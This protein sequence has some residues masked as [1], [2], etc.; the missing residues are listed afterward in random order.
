MKGNYIGLTAIIDRVK[1]N[2]L[3]RGLDF[4]IAVRYAIDCI[5]LIGS[6]EILTE[7]PYRIGIRDYR[8]ILPNNI[9]VLHQARR[10]FLDDT[11]KE[12]Y[13]PMREATDTFHNVYNVSNLATKFSSNG[14]IPENAYSINEYYIHTGFEEGVVDIMYSGIAVDTYGYPLIPD[15]VAI[16][17]AIENYMKQEYFTIL[18]DLDKIPDKTLEKVKQEY[19]WY[20]GK[21]QS[22]AALAS[23]DERSTISNIIHKMFIEREQHEDFYRNLGSKEHLRRQI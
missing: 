6:K 18:S 19:C 22:E 7:I 21:A 23:L 5:K 12:Y 11:D 16:V 3:M 13:E 17:K 8:G 1:T 9:V 15:N 4:D 14:V 2:P 10:V 20:I